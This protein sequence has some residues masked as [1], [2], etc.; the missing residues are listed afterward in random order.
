MAKIGRPKQDA[1]ETRTRRV[2]VC[3][4]EAERLEL[5]DRATKAGFATLS[6]YIR[7]QS[8]SAPLKTH[9][10][11]KAGGVFNAEDRR[12]LAAI[13]NNLNQIARVMNS[14]RAH[15]MQEEM[16]AALGELHRLFDRYLPE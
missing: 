9:R 15:V 13:G 12:A 4:T 3:L 1:T 14:G 16:Q 2:A 11:H 10:P 8:L 6:D 7:A 5:D